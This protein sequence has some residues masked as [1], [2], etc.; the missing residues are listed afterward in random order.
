MDD[1]CAT[2]INLSLSIYT[3]KWTCQIFFYHLYLSSSSG[4][5][6]PHSHNDSRYEFNKLSPNTRHSIKVTFKDSES[7]IVNTVL[8]GYANTPA[9][10]RKCSKY[11]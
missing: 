10:L 6:S 4:A 3:Q 7:Q 1:V 5:T 11:M 8:G 2:S 9:S